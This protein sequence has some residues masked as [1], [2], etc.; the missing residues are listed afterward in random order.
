MNYKQKYFKHYD[1]CPDDVVL[2]KVCGAKAVDIHHIQKKG[3]GKTS[4]DYD[5]IDNL[6]PLCRDCHLRAHFQKEPYLYEKE[7][8]HYRTL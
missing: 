7:L 4:K 1:I 8:K 6:I 2:C 3:M 5:N